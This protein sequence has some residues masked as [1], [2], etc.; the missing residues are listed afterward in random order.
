MVTASSRARASGSSTSSVTSPIARASSPPINLAVRMIS[1]V[2]ASPSSETSR[3]RLPI[4]RQ[5]PSVRAIG[6][7]K[8]MSGEAMRRSQQ[9]AMAAPPPVQAPRMAAMVGTGTRSSES[10]TRSMRRS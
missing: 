9:A 8:A 3:A 10:S 4:D 6:K 7:P 2:R 1:R 5:L